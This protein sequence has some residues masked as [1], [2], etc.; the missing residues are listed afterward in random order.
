MCEDFGDFG[1]ESFLDEHNFLL[2]QREL[3]AMAW[4]EQQDIL[5]EEQAL[6][7]E[8]A[9]E[10]RWELEGTMMS[11]D[12]AD[13]IRDIHRVQAG[14]EPVRGDLYQNYVDLFSGKDVVLASAKRSRTIWP[15]MPSSRFVMV[16]APELVIS[17]AAT[18]YLTV[19]V[20]SAGV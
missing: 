8:M 14:L 16:I 18:P 10:A 15:S 9:C 7:D 5:F 19:G 1:D 12:G 2:E 11:L 13:L 4:E 20:V 3:D 6:A 17:R